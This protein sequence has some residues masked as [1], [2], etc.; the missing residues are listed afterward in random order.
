MEGAESRAR[1]TKQESQTTNPGGEITKNAPLTS[2]SKNAEHNKT[3]AVV[4]FVTDSNRAAVQQHQCQQRRWRRRRR[5]LTLEA[6]VA[7]VPI[8]YLV[9]MSV[10]K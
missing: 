8:V 4:H 1:A 3:T 10:I 9:C 6:V 5:R 7:V 2:S